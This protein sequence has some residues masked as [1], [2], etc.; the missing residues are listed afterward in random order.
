MFEARYVLASTLAAT[1][2]I[3]G[4]AFELLE[5]VPRE[6]G[7]EEY[8]DS[9]KYQVRTW[10]L[11][12][13]DSLAPLIS[14]VNRIRRDHPALHSNER[15]AFHDIGDDAL[16]AYT[17]RTAAG[18]D[19][20]LTV[21]SIDP[22]GRRGGTL[23]LHYGELGFDQGRPVEAIDLLAGGTERWDGDGPR[24]ELV[25]GVRQARILALS[26]PR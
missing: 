25:P 3:Y 16:L 6:P 20:V 23:R 4:P 10:D 11:E 24:I 13:P 12:R 8:R 18:D 2:G 17:K 26:Q 22:R 14:T 21:V 5:H 19:V 15:L 1:Y 9:E 7:S